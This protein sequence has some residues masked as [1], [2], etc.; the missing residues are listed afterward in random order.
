MSRSA[1]T[2]TGGARLVVGIC[3][4]H[5][6][7]ALRGLASE[8]P[9]VGL[10]DA[11]RRSSG[12]VLLRLDCPGLCA[13]GAVGLVGARGSAGQVGTWLAC[14]QGDERRAALVRWVTG[15]SVAGPVLPR[16]PGVLAESVVP[17]G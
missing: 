7:R 15:A 6:C 9:L 17:G 1:R 10:G 4:G 3:D 16:L 14:V 12:A 13:Y 2:G 5:R 8:D 11:V